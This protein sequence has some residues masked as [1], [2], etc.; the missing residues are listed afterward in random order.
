MVRMNQKKLSGPGQLN[1]E[2]K[3]TGHESCNEMIEIFYLFTS[4]I[5][6]NKHKQ[7]EF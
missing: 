7:Q 5:N 6:I 4:G 2:Q 1:N 3:H